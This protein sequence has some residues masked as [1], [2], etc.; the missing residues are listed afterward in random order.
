MQRAQRK[1]AR[2]TEKLAKDLLALYDDLAEFS[3]ISSR[4]P[5]FRVR[6]FWAATL[7]AVQHHLLDSG[8]MLIC[9]SISANC[10]VRLFIKMAF[11][12]SVPCDTALYS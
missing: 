4:K 9:L 11:R 2:N 7:S 1:Y 6:A 10:K 3:S 12:V 8:A 5:T